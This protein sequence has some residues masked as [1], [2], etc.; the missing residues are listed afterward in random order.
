LGLHS[1]GQRNSFI[2]HICWTLKVKR[3]ARTLIESKSNSIQVRLREAG[4][5]RAF[6]KVLPQQALPIKLRA[7][8]K[9]VDSVVSNLDQ[10]L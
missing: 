5:I 10:T 8:V 3:L 4:Q 6:W 2:E 1:T 7:H 9:V